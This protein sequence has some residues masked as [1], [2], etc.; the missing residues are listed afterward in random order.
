MNGYRDKGKI[1]TLKML[2]RTSYAWKKPYTSS[3]ESVI[4]VLPCAGLQG[5]RENMPTSQSS[6]LLSTP[7]YFISPLLQLS[8]LSKLSHSKFI[9]PV[10]LNQ[11]LKFR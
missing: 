8:Y 10:I 5:A 2:K 3:L 9:T 6:Y 4:T 11:K 1:Y 7:K